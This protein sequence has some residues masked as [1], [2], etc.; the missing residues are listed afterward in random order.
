[1]NPLILI[2]I[3]LIGGMLLMTRSAKS[4]QRQALEMRNKME[5]GSGVRTIGGMYAVVK[6]V[7]DETVLLEL[8]DGVHA[9]FTKGAISTVLSEQEFNRIVHGI[10]PEEPEDDT[11][12]ADGTAAADEHTADPV[13]G[14]TAATDHDAQEPDEDRVELKKTEH[15][16]GLGSTDSTPK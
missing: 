12:A 1:M 5:P 14:E 3:V 13:T 4:K 15:G 7:N 6:E 16:S 11:E 2:F 8:T 9:H 10:E